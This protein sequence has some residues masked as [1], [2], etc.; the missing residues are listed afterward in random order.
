MTHIPD[1]WQSVTLGS[2]CEF[3]YG[4]SLPAAQR[5]GGEFY[6]FG[7]NGPVGSHSQ[8]FTCGPT[9]VVGR[10]G[11]FGEVH[12]SPEACWPIDTTYFID[13]SATSADLK[14]LSHLLSTLGLTEMNRAAAIPGLN[15]KD[16]YVKSV[17]LP[18]L[19]EQKRIA[20]VLDQVDTLRAKRREAIALLDDLAQSIFIDMFGD[21]ASPNSSW[22]RKTIGELG[23]VV[24]GNTPSRARPENYGDGIE[25]IKTDNIRPPKLNPSQAAERLT[26][27]GERVGRVVPAEAILVTCIAG[28]PESIGNSALA[29]R[30]VAINQQINAFIPEGPLP[31]FMLEQ[32]RVGKVLIQRKSTGAMTGLVNKSQFSSISLLVPP[33][34]RQ[35][36]FVRRVKCVDSERDRNVRHLAIL[37]ELFTSLQHRAFAGTLW[38]HEAPGEAA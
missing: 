7:S 26:A 21:P 25:W 38:E 19:T 13:E 9:V 12:Y 16:A 23:A 37:D 5:D 4:K 20:A 15:R 36:E 10:K 17:L 8:A 1:G 3:K 34:D 30:R 11:S 35:Q 24:T 29:G 14:W 22:D 28:S 32:I 18:S 6:V 33:V 2:F 31:R 27:A